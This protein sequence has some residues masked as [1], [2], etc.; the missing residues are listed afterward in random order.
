MGFILNL[1]I[2]LH[3]II[4]L[5]KKWV[6]DHHSLAASTKK[7]SVSA[8]AVKC[9]IYN[10]RCCQTIRTLKNFKP[11]PQMHQAGYGFKNRSD[12]FSA[13]GS[14]HFFFTTCENVGV[15]VGRT[16]KVLQR[17]VMKAQISPK[18]ALCSKKSSVPQTN[19]C[20]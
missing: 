3:I 17:N 19:L 18:V 6:Q 11:E 7:I 14:Q 20:L 5:L 16:Y 4:R 1:T 12:C 9:L 10:K 15:T 2:R 8:L 13:G